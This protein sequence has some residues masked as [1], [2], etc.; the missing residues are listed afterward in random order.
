[1]PGVGCLCQGGGER[2]GGG[3]TTLPAVVVP[4]W[5][6]QAV[7]LLCPSP[8]ASGLLAAPGSALGWEITS[9]S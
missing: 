3:G 7:T 4:G 1:M 5:V 9:L 6:T 2:G 8:V